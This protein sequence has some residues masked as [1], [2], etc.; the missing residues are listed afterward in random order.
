MLPLVAYL[1]Q[2]TQMRF[3]VRC[4]PRLSTSFS[5]KEHGTAPVVST[6]LLVVY[7][8]PVEFKILREGE[9]EWEVT[10]MVVDG[11]DAAEEGLPLVG[12]GG[13]AAA[14][15]GAPAAAA[16]SGGGGRRGARRNRGG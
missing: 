9:E 14:H 3:H 16:A 4:C 5:Y 1:D 10:D 2:D 8:S 15:G 13:R 12:R 6:M 7:I 11:G